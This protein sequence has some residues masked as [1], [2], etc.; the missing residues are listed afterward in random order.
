MAADEAC[1]AKSV[2]VVAVPARHTDTTATA[3]PQGCPLLQAHPKEPTHGHKVV[4]QKPHGPDVRLGEDVDQFFAQTVGGPFC[5]FGFT[6]WKG[7]YK[8]GTAPRTV[9]WVF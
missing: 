8:N 2:S 6:T 1:F 4:A 5:P 3:R 9:N 7:R